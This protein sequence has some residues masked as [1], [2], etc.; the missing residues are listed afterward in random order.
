M[1]NFDDSIGKVCPPIGA[2]RRPEVFIPASAGEDGRVK[3]GRGRRHGGTE[4]GASITVVHDYFTQQGGAERVAILL[5][6]A[7]GGGAVTTSAAIPAST[8][9]EVG[10]LEVRELL[11]WLPRALVSR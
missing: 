5:A 2:T 8:F 10:E 3:Q 6:R 4:S 7:H 11:R 1:P 9:P